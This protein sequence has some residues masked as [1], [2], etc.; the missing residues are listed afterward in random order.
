MPQRSP[1]ASEPRTLITHP[2][3]RSQRSFPVFTTLGG[4]PKNTIE[5][6]LSVF[7][8]V[9]AGEGA[10]VLLLTLTVF[11]LL[12]SYYLLKI[13]REA[14]ILTEGGAEVKAY[15]AA[16][17]AVLLLAVV[18]LYGWLGSRVPRMTLIT[19]TTLFFASNLAL[20]YLAGTAGA[21]TGILF[22]IWIGIFN[23]FVVSQFWAF[24]NDVYTEGQGRRLFPL[25]GVGSSLGAWIGATAAV[26]LV[27]RAR[28]TP[29]TL[30]VAGAAILVVSLGLTYAVHVRETSRAEPEAAAIGEQPLGREGGFELVMKDRYLFWIAMLTIV[31]NIVNTSGE[32][33][34]G[35]LV[36]DQA[37]S[38]Y[39]AAQL[40]E[41]QRYIAGFYGSFF[42]A[43]NLLGL[44]LQLFVT[45][46]VIRW[47]GV[48]G[49]LFILPVLALVNYSIIAVAPLLAVVRVTKT[50]DNSVD[51][52]IQNTIRQALF[53]PTTREAKYKAK[54]AI[55]TFGMRLGDV[56]Q[57]GIVAAGT[58]LRIGTAGFAWL[59]VA[60]TIG[61]LWIAGQVA[62]EH[63]KRTL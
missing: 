17:Q 31:L 47:L 55:D 16:A 49:A 56:T 27:E 22:Y 44:I 36:V 63:R 46:R 28:F 34:L 9:R 1:G 43:V 21:R 62:R 37:E 60:L 32:F 15:S 33:L 3:L 6:A 61:W 45:S 57:A 25:I 51:Y 58:S 53:L 23:V 2:E 24:A 4:A 12:G 29:F 52:S 10:G 54:A 48:R 38:L 59:N 40:V 50:L 26:P 7:A 39:P 20:F 19:F 5:R 18:P 41:R 13:A 35:R 30:M 14:L 11:L 8:D 42:G